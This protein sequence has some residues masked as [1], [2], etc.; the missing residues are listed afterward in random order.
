VFRAGPLLVGSV[1]SPRRREE[2]GVGAK[3]L[4]AELSM[5]DKTVREFEFGRQTPNGASRQKIERGLGWRLG[6]IEDAL[7][8]VSRKASSIQMEDLDAEDSLHI[9]SVSGPGLELVSNEA[10]I[11]E[12]AR[13]LSSR[14]GPLQSGVAQSLYGLAA[15]TNSEHLEDVDGEGFGK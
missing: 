14:P 1:A 7:N 2:L 4:A 3:A 13:R 10:L 6:S 8:A 12:L 9:S 5:S 11:G 15:S